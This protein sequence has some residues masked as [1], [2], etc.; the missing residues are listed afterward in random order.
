MMAKVIP[1]FSFHFV[2]AA[3]FSRLRK[4]IQNTI[5]L[6]ML[7]VTIVGRSTAILYAGNIIQ[8]T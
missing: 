6:V 8:V 7:A 1:I 3:L 4:R 2:L 5:P